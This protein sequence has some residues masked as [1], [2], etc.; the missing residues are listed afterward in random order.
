[1]RVLLELHTWVAAF[2]FPHQGL[3]IIRRTTVVDHVANLAGLMAFDLGVVAGESAL[4]FAQQHLLVYLRDLFGP[5]IFG[6]MPG[7]TWPAGRNCRGTRAGV[8]R[9]VEANVTSDRGVPST[10]MYLPVTGGPS[11]GWRGAAASENR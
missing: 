2:R 11:R 6:L 1:V 3:H 9:T 10:R 5:A 8:R 7:Y 4:H